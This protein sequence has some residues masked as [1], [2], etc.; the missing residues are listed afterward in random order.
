MLLVVVNLDVIALKRSADTLQVRLREAGF[1]IGDTR[2]G[3]RFGG[4]RLSPGVNQVR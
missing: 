2:R 4:C 3:C 1:P